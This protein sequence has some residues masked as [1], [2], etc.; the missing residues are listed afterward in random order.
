MPFK[1]VKIGNR[2]DAPSPKLTS[3]WLIFIEKNLITVL[4]V[5]SVTVESLRDLILV[6]VD[7]K[8]VFNT[9]LIV[10]LKILLFKDVGSKTKSHPP[11]DLLIV[12]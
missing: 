4:N 7:Y 12:I 5:H 1:N 2:L 9:I 6:N 8:K 3:F 11:K 10:V